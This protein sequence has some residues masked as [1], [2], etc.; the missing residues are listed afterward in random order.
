M[1]DGT[2]VRYSTRRGHLFHFT[3]SDEACVI[4]KGSPRRDSSSC[5]DSYG[6]ASALLSLHSDAPVCATYQSR[7]ERHAFLYLRG[8]DLLLDA[9]RGL[10]HV[11]TLPRV[12]DL[13]AATRRLSASMTALIP[14]LL[15]LADIKNAGVHNPFCDNFTVRD[16]VRI[17]SKR[18]I[19][20]AVA[21]H[22]LSFV[23]R[24][25]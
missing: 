19:P 3:G 12:A 22:A 5:A 7:D 14:P 8:R 2:V 15:E 23:F 4:V 18:G 24:C 10:V 11:Q 13:H 20:L 21:H 6:A 1:S 9:G 17:L 16:L 25:I